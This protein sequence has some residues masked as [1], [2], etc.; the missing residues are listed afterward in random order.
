MSAECWHCH[1]PLE[2][3]R[4]HRAEYDSEPAF[5]MAS[6]L[7]LDFA[8]PKRSQQRK[9]I[10]EW[11]RLD[12]EADVDRV[13]AR[14]NDLLLFDDLTSKEDAELDRLIDVWKVHRRN[15]RQT[16]KVRP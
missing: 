4:P 16:G 1:V 12:L 15:A 13:V 10:R 3:R 8:F 7:W 5:L 11:D 6:A 2:P 9:R 14:I